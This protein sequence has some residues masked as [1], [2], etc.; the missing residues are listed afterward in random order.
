MNPYANAHNSYNNNSALTA[1]PLELIL[2][3]YDGA[4]KNLKLAKLHISDRKIEAAHTCLIKAQQIIDEL[5][6]SLDMRYK[7]AKDLLDLYSFMAKEIV[8][9][10]ITKDPKL[11]DP[12]I[13][14]LEELRDAWKSVKNV[15]PKSFKS[16]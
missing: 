16:L 12:V 14:M 13:E 9:A 15:E 7:M 11:I 3:L 2:M 1:S 5:I 8:Q 4:I 10:N 6:T